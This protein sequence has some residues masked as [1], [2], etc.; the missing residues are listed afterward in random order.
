M[1]G[2][3]CYTF[4]IFDSANNGICCGFEGVIA[5]ELT[6]LEGAS[7]LASDGVFDSVETTLIGNDV[8][9]VDDFFANNPI[10]AYPNP[11]N[12]IL[13]IKLANTNNLP[14][15]Y[16]IYNMLGQVI[17]TKK[18]TQTEDLSIQA[19]SFSEG[20]YYVKVSKGT[21]SSTIPFIKN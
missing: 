12:D 8:L 18:I 13:N 7:I 14:D 1:T 4:E 20:V 9:S 19:K 17:A 10:S 2:S 11:T 16:T 21:S 15:S 3:E 5:Y 6:T